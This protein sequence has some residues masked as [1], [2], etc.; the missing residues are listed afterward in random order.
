MPLCVHCSKPLACECKLAQPEGQITMGCPARDG[1]LWVHVMDDVGESKSGV[2]VAKNK[3]L[4][5]NTTGTGMVVFD[6]LKEATYTA[7][8]TTLNGLARTHDPPA[9]ASRPIKVKPGQISYVSFVLPRKAKLE[10]RT[11]L[12]SDPWV[13][14]TDCAMKIT[15]AV[16]PDPLDTQA[17]VAAFGLVSPGT[18][19]T[20][21]AFADPTQDAFDGGKLDENVTLEPGETRVVPVLLQPRPKLKVQLVL[22]S[23]PTVV[24]EDCPVKITRSDPAIDQDPNAR[25]EETKKGVV[26]FGRLAP[27]KYKVVPEFTDP[28]QVRF[29]LVEPKGAEVELKHGD[30]KSILLEVAPPLYKKVAFVAHCLPTIAKQIWHD[31]SPKGTW[32]AKYNGLATETLDIEKRVLLLKGVIDKAAAQVPTEDHVLKVFMAPECFFLGPNGA[33]RLDAVADL[34]KRLQGLVMDPQ[35]KHWVFAFGTVNGVLE[36]G[37][38]MSELFNMAPVLR[39]GFGSVGKAPEHTRV[40]Q[41]AT[42]SQELPTLDELDD[43]TADTVTH[44][45]V[46]GGFG[47][48]EYEFIYGRLVSEL[49]ATPEPTVGTPPKTLD[50]TLKDVAGTKDGA[51]AGLKADAEKQVNARGRLAIVRDLR[52]GKSSDKADSGAWIDPFKKLLARYAASRAKPVDPGVLKPQ[53]ADSFS[54]EDYSFRCARRPGPW[55]GSANL[56]AQRKVSFALE[57]CADHSGGR[58]K[59]AKTP[60]HREALAKV[61][62]IRSSIVKQLTPEKQRAEKLVREKNE[63]I[64]EAESK[65]ADDKVLSALRLER[66]Q[67]E[68]AATEARQKLAARNDE[69]KVAQAEVKSSEDQREKIDVLLV[70]SAGMT[71][72][73]PLL[74]RPGGFGF[75]CDGWNVD[76][77]RL[78]N[79]SARKGQMREYTNAAPNAP[80][81]AGRNP[82]RP[83]SELLK[84]D[85]DFKPTP[86][87]VNKAPAA[88]KCRVVSLDGEDA[89]GIFAEGPGE[90]HIYEVQDLPD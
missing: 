38:T 64:A 80:E 62:T 61:D 83:H 69:L 77:S 8:I 26:D 74:V 63:A 9:N 23:D 50:E 89:A 6:G 79:F 57:T 34:I 76:K 16:A 10:V 68:T 70:P 78:V 20:T 35:W 24:V 53:S 11:V 75:N 72:T 31:G 25:T 55:L 84:Q 17:G 19:K 49:L 58:F 48:T 22:E 27:G 18:Y 44:E 21:A 82:L 56:P 42:F 73:P 66:D 65:K 46:G 87:D 4:A 60:A 15:C 59:N 51:W 39:G 36:S 54:P 2:G 90:L 5:Q 7:E 81:E 37:G 14:V 41:K 29:E 28:D 45:S 71:L 3:E 30:D 85:K 67:L 40:I 43:Q 86:P 33:Y 13:T 32:T 12:Q 52:L 47:A 1:A 88:I